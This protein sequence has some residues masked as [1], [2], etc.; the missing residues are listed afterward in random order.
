MNHCPIS[1]SPDIIWEI[2]LIGF[3][4]HIVENS[5]K[6]RN[7]FVNFQG[8]EKLT[9][10]SKKEK[11]EDLTNSDWIEIFDDFKQK[12]NKSVKNN[13]I[14]LIEP[15]FSTTTKTSLTAAHA[16]INNVFNEKLF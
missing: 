9:F 7:K 15:N 4:T 3:S 14:H 11:I 8:K 16:C 5:E 2:I 10:V 6:L 1:I 12:L 13:I